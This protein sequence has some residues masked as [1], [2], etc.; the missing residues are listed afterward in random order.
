MN[1]SDLV[2]DG[3]IFYV[4]FVK[5]TTGEVREM[6][7][8]KGVHSHLKGGEASYDPVRAGLLWVFDMQKQGYRSIPLETI[9]KAKIGGVE[10]KV[11]KTGHTTILNK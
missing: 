5:R 11:D 7:C 2:E 1:I 3:K 6:V 9:I 8:R 4:E 10:Y